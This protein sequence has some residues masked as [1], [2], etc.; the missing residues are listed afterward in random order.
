M[1]EILYLSLGLLV[2]A[3]ASAIGFILKVIVETIKDY[4]FD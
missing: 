2:V 4:F 3:V 1:N